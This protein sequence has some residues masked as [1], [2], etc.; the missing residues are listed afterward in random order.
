MNATG[1][2]S[3]NPQ[4]AGGN[5]RQRQQ[6]GQR[7]QPQQQQQAGG[8]QQSGSGSDS[9]D[10]GISREEAQMMMQ[11]AVNQSKQDNRQGALMEGLSDATDEALQE[12]ASN[13]GGLA[14]TMQTVIEEALVQYA[15]ENPEWVIENMDILQTIIG[16]TGSSNSG[17]EAGDDNAPEE[18]AKVDNAL[19]DIMSGSS[20]GQS[21][22]DQRQQQ[23]GQ[24][25]SQQT[26]QSQ[27]TP[28]RASDPNPDLE[29]TEEHLGDSGFEPSNMEASPQEA[30]SHKSEQSQSAQDEAQS[31]K[32]PSEPNKSEAPDTS[33]SVPADDSGSEGDGF[34]EIFG[35]MAE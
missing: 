13:V 3:F 15:R 1:T 6:Q 24:Q 11:E 35:D 14:G 2:N 21:Q 22:Q 23:G 10:S 19:D 17:D 28:E 16:A 20:G 33:G 9:G 25:R 30:D 8:Q 12:M 18:D 7:A 32:P 4:A 29:L 34:D 5:Q 27:S 26:Q 31:S